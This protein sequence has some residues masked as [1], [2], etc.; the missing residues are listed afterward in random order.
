MASTTIVTTTV[1]NTFRSFV[2]A[3]IGSLI[4]WGV[5]KWG[6]FNTGSFAFIM[7]V[8]SGLYYTAVNALEKKFPKFGWLLGVLPQKKTATP[9]PTPTPAPAAS[10]TAP[11]KATGVAKKQGKKA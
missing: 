10:K 7:P 5:T 2:A 6:S 9:T 1:R 4:A 3:A 11:K 8:A